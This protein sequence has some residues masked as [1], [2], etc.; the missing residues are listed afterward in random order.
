[1]VVELWLGVRIN[2]EGCE[3]SLFITMNIGLDRF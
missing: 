1:M 2:I 3:A